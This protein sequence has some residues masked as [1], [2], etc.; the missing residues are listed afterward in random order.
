MNENYIIFKL[1]QSKSI[2]FFNSLRFIYKYINNSFG[3]KK[4]GDK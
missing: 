4:K 2:I 3:N 1:L